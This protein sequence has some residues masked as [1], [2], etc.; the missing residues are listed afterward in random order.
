MS[1]TFHRSPS[2][3]GDVFTRIEGRVGRITLDRP[4]ALNALNHRMVLAIEAVLRAWARDD[5]VA[6]VLIDGT[7]ERAFCAGGDIRAVYEAA[8][9]GDHEAGRAFWRDEYR[10]NR[11]IKHYPK[12]YV[13]IM[14]GIVMG[15]GVGVSAH[16]SHRVVTERTL[17]AM[18]ECG[19]G[20]V[21]D[22]GGSLILAKAPGRLGEYLGLTGH[23]MG[24]ADAIFAGFADRYVRSQ[25]L[26][27]LKE[28]L[29]QTGDPAAIADF[30]DEPGLGRLAGW[31][32]DI[33]RFFGLASVGEIVAALEA[34][35]GQFAG[36]TVEALR[37]GAPLSL[38][39]TLDIIRTVR[40]DPT[41]ERALS[42][43]FR[44]TYRAQEL[45]DH[46]EGIRAAVID[47]DRAP[48]WPEVRPQDLA[49]ERLAAM[50]APLEAQEL[51]WDELDREETA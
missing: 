43:E 42:E 51:H 29:V 37:K 28:A 26:D 27:R 25:D 24:P 50:R 44:F 13:A 11:L 45:G 33:D 46:Q 8:K 21:P 38:A 18:P 31:M 4:K 12:P 15:G 6:L 48:H 40:V 32:A 23:R 10:L 3:T 22:V 17:L 16:G 9:A 35:E 5:R 7:G 49:P 1:E 19:I 14:D 36:E 34:G 47:K 39:A 30:E 20:L 41:I 2:D